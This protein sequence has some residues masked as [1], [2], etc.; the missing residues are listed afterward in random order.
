MLLAD[1]VQKYATKSAADEAGAE[2]ESDDDLSSVG[3]YNDDDEEAQPAGHR[4][5]VCWC[6]EGWGSVGGSL[7]RV[8]TRKEGMHSPFKA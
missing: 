6:D 2:S 3:S 5:D 8:G 4:A 1:Y 7:Q